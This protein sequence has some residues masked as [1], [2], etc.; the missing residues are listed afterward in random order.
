M[1]RLLT[2][3]LFLISTGLILVCTT[4]ARTS[5]FNDINWAK[6]GDN[7]EAGMI[8][9]KINQDIAPLEL[10]TFDGIPMTGIPSL[11]AIADAFGV[12]TISKTYQMKTP[13][14]DPNIP[15]L[16]HFYTVFFP[17]EFGPFTLIETYES[18][19]EVE[20]AEFV[21]INRFFYTPNDTRFRNQWHLT[22]CGLP[23][24]WDVSHGSEEIVIGIVDNGL[25][26]DIDRFLTVHEDF[27]INLWQNPGEDL[28]DDGECTWEDDFNDEDDDENGFTDDFHGWDFTNNDNW[29]DDEWGEDGGHGTHVAGCA[30]ADTDN[31]TG[32]AAP[33]FNCQLMISAHY[34]PSDPEGGIYFGYRGIEYCGANGANVINI[35][36]GYY[37]EPNRTEESAVNY[38]Q[39]QGAIIFA[40][41]GNENQHERREDARRSYPCGYDYVIGV[42]ACDT[43]DHKADFS[44]YGD[45]TDLVAPGVSILSAWP[46]NSYAP[47]PG[48]SMASPIAAGIGAL[49]LSVEPNLDAT[50]L[51]AWMQRT[52]VD[53]SDVGDNA[54]YPGIVYRVNADFLLNSTNPRYEISEWGFIETE[55]DDDGYIDRN[56]TISL[57][58][59]IANLEGYTD[60][61]DVTISLESD[62]RWIEIETDE[63]AISDINA[64]DSYELWEDEYPTFSVSSRS[65]IHYTT[66]TLRINSNDDY[67]QVVELPMTIRHP[68]YLL[69]DDDD[70]NRMNEYYEEDL[71]TRPIVHE[72]WDIQTDG[73]PTQEKINEYSFVIWETGNS[74]DPLSEAEQNLISGYLNNS[75]YLLISGQYIGDAH[76]ETDFHR[77]YLK[78]NHQDDDASGTRIFGVDD[79][80]MTDGLDL[81][82]V[83]G[84]GAGNGRESP[85][86]MEPIGGAEAILHYDNDD[87]DVAGIYYAGDYHL[88]YL[89]FALEAVSG[90]AN[91]TLRRE[92]VERILDYFYELG[93]S[94]DHQTAIPMSFE[95]GQPHPNPFN[96]RTSVQ[97]KT[98]YSAAYALEV[99]DLT[100]RRVAL[101]HDGPAMQGIRTYHWNARNVPAGVYLINLKWT[102]G[103][104]ARKVVLIK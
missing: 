20:F 76:G 4:D 97:V 42:G 54:D 6:P 100:G 28:N 93:V 71:M 104:I 29:P 39:S 55:G 23:G 98:P 24:A 77:N 15:D 90:N 64:G 80:P 72:N 26:M 99:M 101:L 81:L 44:T 38:A 61:E 48:T 95:L 52:A 53:I 83:G 70:G 17:E 66:F 3:T 74:Q 67:T 31:E 94:E 88:V 9:I 34:N 69:V 41:A 73:L 65:P 33:G 19:S 45:F 51:L 63:I 103:S 18:C 21:S 46:R 86:S 10:K 59:T 92:A 43:R 27:R 50:E 62:D 75:G 5:N 57:N 12:Y 8:Y 11:D 84:G 58:M 49:M 102:E 79:N 2:L 85:S 60:G 40:A 32:I 82:L 87:T 13:P 47:A 16:S 78:T 22:H 68:L 91:T 1:L 89:G 7:V 96:A 56:E 37:G 35:S 36:W 30:S 25:D 14:K